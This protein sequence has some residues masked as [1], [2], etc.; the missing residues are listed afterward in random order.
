MFIYTCKNCKIKETP[1]K[2]IAQLPSKN[3]QHNGDD[4]DGKTKNIVVDKSKQAK[5]WIEKDKGE[6]QNGED[7][8]LNIAGGSSTV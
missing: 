8:S 1:R 6:I 4:I 5:I 2:D 3:N 7:V